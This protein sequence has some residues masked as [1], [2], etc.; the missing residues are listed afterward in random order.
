VALEYLYFSRLFSGQTEQAGYTRKQFKGELAKKLPPLKSRFF[1]QLSVEYLYNAGVDDD[2][3]LNPEEIYPLSTPGIQSTTRHFS[4]VSLTFTNGL[5]PGIRLSHALTLLAKSNHFFSNDGSSAF[6][7]SGQQV[8]QYQYYFSPEFTTPSGTTFRPMVHLVRTSSQVPLESGQ[9]FQGGAGMNT[10]GYPSQTN[11]A[12]G[13]GF[14]KG[15]GNLDLHLGTYYSNLN[16]AD[17]VQGR[18]GMTWFPLGN[19][20]LYTGVY[21]NSQYESFQGTQAILRFVPEAMFG[22]AIAEKVWIDL[23]GTLGEM[24]NYLENKGMI[25]YNS[26]NEVIEKKMKISLSIPVTERASLFYLGGVWSSNRSDFIASDRSNNFETNSIYYNAL[27][28]YGGLLWK[29]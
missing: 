22:F 2:I 3:F 7:I 25:V 15:L 29:F 4:N 21:A 28:I 5:A 24:T 12:T 23:R 10:V 14:Q 13:L 18:L 9:G 16:Q 17:Q 11:I 6:Y 20:N 26:L 8:V 1:D 27:S 19:L